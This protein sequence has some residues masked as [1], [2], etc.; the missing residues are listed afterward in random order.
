MLLAQ[1]EV[2]TQILSGYAENLG[3]VELLAL[4]VVLA[5]TVYVLAGARTDVAIVCLLT[6]SLLTTADAKGLA[7]TAT[8]GRWYFLFLAAISALLRP[9]PGD[10]GLIG[11]LSAYAA[12]NVVGLVYGPSFENGLVR[13][14][15][16]LAAIPAFMLSLGP[17]RFTMDSLIKFI[18]MIAVVGIVLA[19][20]HTWFILI[21]PQ[22]GGI[23]RF[24]SFY[25][26]PQTMSLA[27][28]A[29]TLPMVWLLLSKSAGRWFWPVLFGALVNVV[30][31][32]ASTQRTG[33]FSLGGA[34]VLMLIFYRSRGLLI[35]LGAAAAFGLIAMPIVR[36][37]VASPLLTERLTSFD[38]A[39]RS[40]IWSVA[41]AGA[42]ENPITG[43]GSGAG[44]YFSE[45][46]FGKKFHQA[47]LQVFYDFGIPGLLVFL[48]LIG[49]GVFIAW[50]LARDHDPKRKAIGVFLIAGIAQVCAQ[51][52]FETSMADTTNETA[53]LFFISLGVAAGA[54]RMPKATWTPQ[55]IAHYWQVV[56]A[57]AWAAYYARLG[58]QG[59][60]AGP[61]PDAPSAPVPPT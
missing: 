39:G 34:T 23:S 40:E 27:T 21:A 31:M 1:F 6:L 29:V 45:T 46:N 36:Y 25:T 56:R 58:Q 17:P 37:L 60:A 59:A 12:I 52:L 16:F 9:G 42:M 7:H 2:I 33:L 38:P 41:F 44:T 49:R 13:A 61:T 35:A 30:V 15:F 24:K 4:F 22:G 43:H 50:T 26:S 55:Q 14:L 53:T 8:L 5:V 19:A 51:G 32:V 18:R 3:V 47:Y 48:A 20:L 57:R 11:L 54:A 28:A 10:G